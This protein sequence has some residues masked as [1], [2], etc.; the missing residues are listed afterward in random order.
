M[1]DLTCKSKSLFT[2]FKVLEYINFHNLEFYRAESQIIDVIINIIIMIIISLS[3]SDTSSSEPISNK[4]VVQK[5]V[6]LPR[7][8]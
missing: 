3:L 7:A 8:L 1:R 4:I 2:L 6:V 5:R